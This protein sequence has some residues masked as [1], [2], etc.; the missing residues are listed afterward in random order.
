MQID[1]DGFV[2]HVLPTIL[3]L[4]K[5]GDSRPTA[6]H[7]KAIPVY[8]NQQP[9]GENAE[10]Y[11]QLVKKQWMGRRRYRYRPFP[12]DKKKVSDICSRIRKWS[13]S[14]DS[15]AVILEPESRLLYFDK[16]GENPRFPGWDDPD[17]DTPT[18]R[19]NIE[20]VSTNDIFN[21]WL[22][23]E[24]W[25]DLEHCDDYPWFDHDTPAYNH[26]T[27]D[28]RVEIRP[29][30]REC[31]SKS[32]ND[33]VEKVV[34]GVTVDGVDPGIEPDRLKEIIHRIDVSFKNSWINRELV[35]DAAATEEILSKVNSRAKE[36][37]FK[38]RID[39]RDLRVEKEVDGHSVPWSEEDEQKAR[40][41][42]QQ[43]RGVSE[44]VKSAWNE[45]LSWIAGNDGENEVEEIPHETDWTPNPKA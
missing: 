10:E 6:T 28:T 17:V 38:G 14:D 37:G 31:H 5:E 45:L 9:H 34:C 13:Q 25:D 16:N 39:M 42:S 21:A 35:T 22:R 26:S 36:D 32:L 4:M 44:S 20:N 27:K 12:R 19:G 2:S 11:A 15:F 3:Y 23:C 18:I 29:W 33:P 40:K 30:T 43:T 7:C 24:D 8:N 1:M 41:E